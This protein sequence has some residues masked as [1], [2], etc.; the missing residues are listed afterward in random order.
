MLDY[1][2]ERNVLAEGELAGPLVGLDE[3]G[4]GP[5]A[6]PVAAA[7]VVLDPSRIPAGLDDS[8]RLTPVERERLEVEVK[9]AAR[10]WAV[11]FACPGEIARLNVVG[12]SFLAM[13]RALDGLYLRPKLALV[14]G[15]VQRLHFPKLGLPAL[16]V[17][18]GDSRAASIAAAS[19]LAKTARDRLMFR[20]AGLFPG[21]GFAE[22]K[23]YGRPAVEALRRLGPTPVH[24][25]SWEA[26][27]QTRLFG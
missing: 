13:R 7:A 21:Y 15:P 3:A 2:F 27:R 24:R 9:A 6:G 18:E 19:I 20:L 8:K 16:G 4:R 14:D 25:W 1:S 5:L 17:V 23:G 11:A 22:N 10:S 26:V 12:A